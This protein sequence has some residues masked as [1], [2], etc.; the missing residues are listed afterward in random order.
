MIYKLAN[1]ILKENDIVAVETLD[2]E[3]MYQVRSI[4]KH[5]NNVPTKITL[6]H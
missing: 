5:L 1:K 2:V 3:S 6:A 4:V